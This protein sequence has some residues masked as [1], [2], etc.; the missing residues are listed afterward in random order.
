M[1]DD[2]V[3]RSAWGHKDTILITFEIGVGD[4]HITAA[5][6]SNTGVIRTSSVST[7]KGDVVYDHVVTTGIENTFVARELAVGRV[8][9]W[10]ATNADNR[11]IFCIP[12][13][14]LVGT[15]V[16]GCINLDN[17]TILELRGNRGNGFIRFVRADMPDG[18][19]TED[20][21]RLYDIELWV[22]CR[23]QSYAGN[24]LRTFTV[25]PATCAVSALAAAAGWP[26]RESVLNP[27]T[28]HTPSSIG[29]QNKIKKGA[30]S[31]LYNLGILQSLPSFKRF[32]REEYEDNSE[33]NKIKKGPI[34]YPTLH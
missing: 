21:W 4:I 7:N 18:A 5:V 14:T 30:R 23:Q 33:G 3:G 13:D 20:V 26:K 9:D 25:W 16:G 19:G 11:Y 29:I 31:N 32:E 27:S 22:I 28:V 6:E 10:L 17:V 1:V 15:V 34:I 12:D 8:V 2:D 24:K